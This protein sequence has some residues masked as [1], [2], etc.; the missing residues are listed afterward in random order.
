MHCAPCYP[1]VMHTLRIAGLIA[2]LLH[3]GLARSPISAIYEM[4]WH[5][6]LQSVAT[7]LR[8]EG[9]QTVRRDYWKG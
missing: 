7:G 3:S 6:L 5:S 2:V 4:E 8:R 1:T 9:R